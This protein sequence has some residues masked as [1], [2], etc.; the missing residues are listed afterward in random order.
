[1]SIARAVALLAFMLFALSL[2]GYVRAISEADRLRLPV[3]GPRDR[4]ALEL[5]REHWDNPILRLATLDRVIVAYG[6]P[7]PGQCG[8]V[9]VVAISFFGV[10]LDR[11]RVGC[12]D[13]T[14]SL[15]P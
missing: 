9:D 6:T 2:V 13:S 1:M 11:V 3:T 15:G 12:D 7:G 5:A 10:I 8:W 14:T 4:H